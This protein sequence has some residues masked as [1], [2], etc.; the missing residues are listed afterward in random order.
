MDLKN[1]INEKEQSYEIWVDFRGFEIKISYLDKGELQA[2]LKRSKSREYDRR[3][4]QPVEK[5][6][7]EKL[8]M[9]L[10][11]LIMDWRGLTLSKLA[12]MVPINI[13][14]AEAKTPVPY[15]KTNAETLVKEA[16]GLDNFLMDKVTDLQ[17][18]REEKLETEV[19]NSKASHGNI[20]SLAETRAKNVTLPL[21]TA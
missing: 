5:Y 19:K 8:A 2:V 9:N 14:E 17:A 15:S 4:H 21:E 3:S 13:S 10:A 6:S 12:E 11:H 7:D 18:F 20:S 1:I 16:Y